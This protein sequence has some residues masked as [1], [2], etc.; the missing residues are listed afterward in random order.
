[1][2]PFVF[3]V[4]CE[5][6]EFGAHIAG[7]FSK[8][9]ASVDGYNLACILVLPPYQRRG[10]GKFLISL[11]YEL[12]R[13]EGKVGSPEQPISDLGKLSYRSYWSH[14]VLSK[15]LEAKD[16]ITL[17]ELSRQTAIRVEDIV[18]TL[19]ALNLIKYWRGVHVVSVSEDLLRMH[20]RDARGASSFCKPECIR[21]RPR[22][23]AASASSTG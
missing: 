11:S 1:M 23:S 9:V 19:L 12:S 16:G 8:E 2:H 15:L 14:V 6:D 4:L 18:S 5:V 20:L 10:Y 3:Y 13:I 7:Y 17:K 22:P 21:W